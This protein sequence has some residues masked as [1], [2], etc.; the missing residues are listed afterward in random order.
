M[1][2]KQITVIECA[3]CC[4]RMPPRARFCRRCGRLLPDAADPQILNAGGAVGI[5]KARTGAAI[6]LLVVGVLLIFGGIGD[7]R[8]GV[9]LLGTFLALVGFGGLWRP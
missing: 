8:A 9:C 4:T 3:Q 5:S 1:R 6:T 7:Q 2:A